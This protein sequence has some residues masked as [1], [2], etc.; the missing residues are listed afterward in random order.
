MLQPANG[1]R[2][3]WIDYFDLLDALKEPKGSE[4]DSWKRV[5]EQ[6]LGKREVFGNEVDCGE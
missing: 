1:K 5:I 3:K 4:A 2:G 6:F